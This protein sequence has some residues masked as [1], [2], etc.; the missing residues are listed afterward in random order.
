MSIL[1]V[2]ELEQRHLLSSGFT[3]RMI[4][5]PR[6]HSGG[7]A[8]MAPNLDAAFH[9]PPEGPGHFGPGPRQIGVLNS[10]PPE[11]LFQ[12]PTSAPIRTPNIGFPSNEAEPPKPISF[13]MALESLSTTAPVRDLSTDRG[14]PP[15]V[16][17]RFNF[18]PTPAMLNAFMT[19]P[20][21]VATTTAVNFGQT[22]GRLEEGIVAPPI[23]G[24]ANRPS[25]EQINSNSGKNSEVVKVRTDSA[26]PPPLAFITSAVDIARLSRGFKQFLDGIERTAERV[27]ES[28]GLRTWIAAGAVAAIACELA[29]RQLRRHSADTQRRLE[30]AR[31]TLSSE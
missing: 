10:G 29:R 14:G 3:H 22:K 26:V 16:A 13:G 24:P 28:D 11:G 19:L 1:R 17:A 21:A 15:T 5:M 23:V 6:N 7:T 31:I 27:S 30:P 20:S 9:S 12:S 18:S 2:E 8:W 25:G 4:P